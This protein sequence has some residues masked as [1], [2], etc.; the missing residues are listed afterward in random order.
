MS[1][2]PPKH[3]HGALAL[4][5]GAGRRGEEKVS[6]ANIIKLLKQISSGTQIRK[7]KIKEHSR[8]NKKAGNKIS[9][10]VIPSLCAA[11]S[12][13]VQLY[14]F[15]KFLCIKLKAK[16]WRNSS[17]C[18]VT[19]K[20]II[21]P[22]IQ[23]IS[24]SSAAIEAAICSHSGPHLYS[25]FYSIWLNHSWI[26]MWCQNSEFKMIFLCPEL[27]QHQRNLHFTL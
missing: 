13:I 12:T 8:T 4:A 21:F 10:Y 14:C 7:A 19:L 24:T 27:C 6:P 11:V 17:L 20:R 5:G 18:C 2:P 22:I 25:W 16:L 23:I 26:K 9:S 1:L 15:G 3:C